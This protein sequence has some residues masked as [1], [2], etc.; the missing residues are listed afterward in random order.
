[1]LLLGL[2]LAPATAWPCTTFLVQDGT[3]IAV[4]KSYDWHMG[5]G[6]VLTNKR[7]VKKQ[8]LVL[9]PRDRPAE[10]TSEHASL[11]FNQYGRE[12]PNGG[13]NDAGLV[14]EIMW[15]DDSRYPPKDRRP[16]VN[17]LQWIQYQ[18]DTAATVAEVRASA[19]ELRV[20]PA[21]GRVHYLACDASGVCA[22][23]E[24]VDGRLVVSAGDDLPVETLTNHTYAASRRHLEKHRGFGGER[25]LPR[26][27]S[28][29]DR[30]VRA[31]ALARAESDTPVVKRAFEILDDVRIDGY[32]KWNIV[33]EPRTRRVH[34]RT[35]EA[36]AIKTVTLSAFPADC[37]TP[38]RMLD[39]DSRRAGDA[40][41]R[42]EPY[43]LDANLRL[44]K[45]S[46][47]KLG[48]QLPK[49]APRMIARY[50]D[51]TACV[52]E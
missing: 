18:L 6:L 39:I 33:Y 43:A 15:L 26:S 52:V 28:S 24:Y 19:D 20:S 44:V 3:Q 32:S 45:R 22:A 38:V 16:T 23:F 40:T 13:I 42:F 49:G 50:P 11:T 48:D 9:D 14:V 4:G 27:S 51:T 31:S 47:A 8:A 30:F 1:M 21:N 34:F 5:Q 46:L 37:S 36:P 17:E 12:M 29:L 25:A 2:L 35:A 10:W 7:G 41:D